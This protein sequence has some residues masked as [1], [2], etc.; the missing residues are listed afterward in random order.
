ME[1]A[2]EGA[3]ITKIVDWTQRELT[4]DTKTES[5][6]AGGQEG[7]DLARVR[8]NALLPWALNNAEIYHKNH[9]EQQIEKYL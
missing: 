2:R 8:Q 6:D 7:D 5:K 1:N 4:V 3:M 9:D